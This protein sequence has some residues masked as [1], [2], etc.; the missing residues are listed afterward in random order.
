MSQVTD[1]GGKENLEPMTDQV[2]NMELQFMYFCW[3][4]FTFNKYSEFL[5]FL[6]ICIHGTVGLWRVDCE[7]SLWEF[8][9]QFVLMSQC[10]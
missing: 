1:V 5:A 6:V 4:F 10:L 8:L 3:V 2:I 7:Q 9:E